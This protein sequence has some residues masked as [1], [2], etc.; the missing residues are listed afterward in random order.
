MNKRNLLFLGAGH[1]AGRMLKKKSGPVMGIGATRKKGPRAI[2]NEFL[3]KFWKDGYISELSKNR[4]GDM[5]F[6]VEMDSLAK[7]DEAKRYL[8]KKRLEI[9]HNMVNRKKFIAYF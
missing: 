2:Y 3:R 7:A 6:E 1:L 4:A 5:M 8:H 9:H